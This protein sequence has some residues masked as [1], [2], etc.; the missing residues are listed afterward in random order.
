MLIYPYQIP[1]QIIEEMPIYKKKEII[2]R[3]LGELINRNNLE[4]TS[5]TPDF[6]MAEYLFDCLLSANLLICA[7]TAWY[8]PSCN[9]M[10]PLVDGMV[11][12]P[13]KKEEK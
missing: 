9:G 4:S 13:P 11:E 6:I 7:R 3:E 1:R 5:N 2:I 10:I 8:N 12:W